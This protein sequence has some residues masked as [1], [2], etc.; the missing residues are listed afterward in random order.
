MS[1][2]VGFIFRI[3]REKTDTTVRIPYGIHRI[4]SQKHCEEVAKRIYKEPFWDTKDWTG[5]MCFFTECD[6][7]H[8]VKEMELCS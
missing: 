7:K 8:K 3:Y 4:T 5:G 6:Y 2:K 1:Q